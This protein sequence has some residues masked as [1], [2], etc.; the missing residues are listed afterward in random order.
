[1]VS[2]YIDCIGQSA[3]IWGER[4]RMFAGAMLSQIQSKRA[5]QESCRFRAAGMAKSRHCPFTFEC[6]LCGECNR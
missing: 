1:M 3:P 6:T 2:S 5:K 4:S